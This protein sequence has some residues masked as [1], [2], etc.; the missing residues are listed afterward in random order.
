MGIQDREYYRE[1]PYSSRQ[2][3][4]WTQTG[5]GLLVLATVLTFVA[6][7]LGGP[8]VTRALAAQPGAVLSGHVWKLLTA[9]FVHSPTNLWH[10]VANMLFLWMLGQEVE[11]LYGKRDFL[12]LYLAA[13]VLA[14]LAECLW[15]ELFDGRPFAR[16]IDVLGASGAVMAVAV[17]CALFYPTKPITIYFVTAP[18]W[19]V[20]VIYLGVDLL[21]LKSQRSGVAHAAH[22]TGAVVGFAYWFFDLRWGR[23]ARGWLPG[24][25][26]ARRR[27]AEVIQ[28]P[29]RAVTTGA[30][31]PTDPVI[32][33]VDQ[34]LAK[35]HTSGMDSL[36]PEELEFLR[37]NSG[38]FRREEDT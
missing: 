26:S 33:R 4:V 16:D 27:T 30:P 24:R 21:G 3:K 23:V 36:S 13:G 11:Q 9:N 34:L 10:I 6:Q 37:T 1:V 29:R 5:V 35:I 28:I 25:R 22:L 8:E 32:E 14:I 12:I 19:I 38:R 2:L 7:L 18:L 20:C 31:Q 17:L 15:L